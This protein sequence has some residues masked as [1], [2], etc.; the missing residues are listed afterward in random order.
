MST[1]LSKIAGG[2]AALAIG[3]TSTVLAK[4]NPQRENFLNVTS[5]TWSN[6]VSYK[7]EDVFDL[8]S[9]K[10]DYSQLNS[11]EKQKW[12]R[13]FADFYKNRDKVRSLIFEELVIKPAHALSL[14]NEQLSHA[15]HI[16][17]QIKKLE[18]TNKEVQKIMQDFYQECR[19]VSSFIFGKTKH[20]NYY[21]NEIKKFI[22]PGEELKDRTAR[23][24][25]DAWIGCSKPGS[26]TSI[27]IGWPDRDE[28]LKQ[29]KSSNGWNKENKRM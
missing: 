18:E 5:E 14:S 19:K 15:Q 12:Q 25:R 13:K 16:E 4:N 11:S 17:D 1:L 29:E 22:N 6:R 7:F 27:D 20:P 23:Y 2:G 8:L 9:T 10:K 21:E 26:T 3:A 24:W 28:I